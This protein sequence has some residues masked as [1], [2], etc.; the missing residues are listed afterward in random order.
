MLR[1][2]SLNRIDEAVEPSRPAHDAGS[3]GL[4]SCPAQEVN[5][6]ADRGFA[7]AFGIRLKP[8]IR[9]Q[10]RSIA[11]QEGNT[12]ASVLRRALAAGL[13]VIDAQKPAGS[14]AGGSSP[15]PAA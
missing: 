1:A 13:A 7:K 2:E 14:L 6:M 5:L 15:R 9:D 3:E 12:E 8:A 10:V 11:E 4:S